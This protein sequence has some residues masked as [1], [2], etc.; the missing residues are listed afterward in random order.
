M[1]CCCCQYE[2]M[3]TL[4][5]WR[6]RIEANYNVS[7]QIYIFVQCLWLRQYYFP[8]PRR[9]GGATFFEAKTGRFG[10]P[11]PPVGAAFFAGAGALLAPPPKSPPPTVFLGAATVFL[12]G[13]T[14]FLAGATVFFAGATVFLAGAT[15]FFAGATVFLAGATVFLGGATVFLAPPIVRFGTAAHAVR[16][17]T[18]NRV[19]G[20][21]GPAII[22][23]W[24]LLAA[25]E[26]KLRPM[27]A[28]RHTLRARERSRARIVGSRSGV[29]R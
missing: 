12:A 10:A 28:T 3:N 29:S 26:E 24:L 9:G 23:W 15:V 8:P 4:S 11:L 17:G 6:D 13:A 1:C 7:P 18:E 22:R 20:A 19:I 25:R 16:E 5:V 2:R 27:K 21:R 14:V